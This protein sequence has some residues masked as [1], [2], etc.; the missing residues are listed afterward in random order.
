[1]FEQIKNGDKVSFGKGIPR[2]GG[3]TFIAKIHK[4][5]NGIKIM[6]LEDMGCGKK[7]G[8]KKPV[9]R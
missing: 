4:D 7:S 8:G 2:I 3:K 9:K 6:G 1:M 5:V